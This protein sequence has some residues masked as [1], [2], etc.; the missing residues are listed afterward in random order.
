MVKSTT[1]VFFIAHILPQLRNVNNV[2]E[3]N[4]QDYTY[5]IYA[6]ND[7]GIHFSKNCYSPLIHT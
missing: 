6:M 1:Y 4:N 5:F 2:F 7:D 3:N